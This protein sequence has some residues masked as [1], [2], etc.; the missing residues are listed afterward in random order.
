MLSPKAIDYLT[1]PPVAGIAQLA[2]NS[3]SFCLDYCRVVGQG[4][5]RDSQNNI[6][7]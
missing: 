2:S 1:K 4:N 3:R 5:S 6:G 7:N